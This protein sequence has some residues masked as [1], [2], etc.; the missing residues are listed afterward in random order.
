MISVMKNTLLYILYKKEN[1]TKLI[2]SIKD[3]LMEDMLQQNLKKIKT[4]TGRYG[5]LHYKADTNH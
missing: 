2:P 4:H 1:P 5:F 3:Y